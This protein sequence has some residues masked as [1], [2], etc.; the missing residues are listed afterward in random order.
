MNKRGMQEQLLGLWVQVKCLGIKHGFPQDTIQQKV[1]L[2]NITW[3]NNLK[4]VDLMRDLGSG[5][6]VGSMLA[7]DSSV[8]RLA[9]QC[10]WLIRSQRQSAHGKRQW[11][12]NVRIFI[13][14]LSGL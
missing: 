1:Y 2:D 6:R 10:S 8:R 12:V 5:M 3:L 9:D 14:A 4:A 7:R 13:S 11:H